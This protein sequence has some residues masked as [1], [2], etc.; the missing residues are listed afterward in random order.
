MHR[1][2]SQFPSTSVI[3]KLRNQQKK[4]LN[5]TDPSGF[6][7]G[8]AVELHKLTASSSVLQKFMFFRKPES[9]NA[10]DENEGSDSADDRVPSAESGI[11]K[12]KVTGKGVSSVVGFTTLFV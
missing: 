4:P 3:I 5:V 1:Y 10:C 7:N 12:G 11:M 2:C 6:I 9:E 8:D